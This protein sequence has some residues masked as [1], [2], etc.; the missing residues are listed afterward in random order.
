MSRWPA[1]PL[2]ILALSVLPPP[3]GAADRG[4][5]TVLCDEDYPPYAFR[6]DEGRLEGIVVDDWKAWELATGTKV[7]LVGLPWAEAL[8]RFDSGGADVLDTVFETAERKARYDF[9]PPYATLSVPVFIH[10][11]LS[12]IASIGDLRGL[13][14]GVKDG[15][16]S[17]GQLI[18]R[19]VGELRLYQDYEEIIRAAADLEL[20]VFCVDE[21]PALYWMYRLGVD[22]DFRIAF[23]L[24]QG[25]F[26]RAVLKGRGDLLAAVEAGFDAVGKSGLAAI[27]RK[28]L[29][30]D[31][32][33]FWSGRVVAIVAGAAL[34]TI[35]VLGALSWTLRRRVAAA[36]AELKDK[37]LLLEAGEARIRASLGEK[38]ILLKEV[39]HRVKNNLQIISSLINLQAQSIRDEGDRELLRETQQRIY[40]M[41]QLHEMLYRSPDLAS[42]D[43]AEYLRSLASALVSSAGRRNPVFALEGVILPLDSA[44]PLGLIANE[45]VSNAIKHAFPGV[46]PY[47]D[48]PGGIAISLAR[49]GPELALEVRDRGP[50]LPAGFDPMASPSMGITLVRSL[51][52]QLG[53]RLS[54]SGPPGLAVLLVFPAPAG[55]RAPA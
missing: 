18:E 52:E 9:T 28:W 25:A 27:E 8:A 1:L 6:N 46:E 49:R 48:E 40:A 15:D 35:L 33:R 17:I 54:F 7:E 2:L 45:L 41:A 16:A 23:A 51:A 4:S 30:S 22:R 39:H 21:P 3:L 10:K 5:I 44:V 43:F 24:S 37:V 13:K 42:I 38:E 14:V 20:R 34:A 19:G 11:S 47:R 29:G 12:G 55:A 32:R 50:G 26:H 31:I 53:G 36:T